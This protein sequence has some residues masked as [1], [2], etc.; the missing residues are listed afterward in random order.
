MDPTTLTGE[1]VAQSINSRSRPGSF[2]MSVKPKR[3]KIIKLVRRLSTIDESEIYCP[4][5]SSSILPSKE[6]GSKRT[7]EGNEI[8]LCFSNIKHS[9]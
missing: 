4:N 8:Y 2:A 1:I 7:L 5:S 3:R 9:I 6:A